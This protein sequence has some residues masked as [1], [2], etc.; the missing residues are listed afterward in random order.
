MTDCLSSSLLLKGCGPGYFS[1]AKG[2]SS[3]LLL[4]NHHDQMGAVF[5]PTKWYRDNIQELLMS[6][7]A[8]FLVFEKVN[9]ESV[10]A[11]SAEARDSVLCYL[12]ME[13]KSTD[14]PSCDFVSF[15]V[16]LKREH[17]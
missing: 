14:N 15:L 12:K 9:A 8:S 2:V 1:S 4:R 6:I 17:S 10:G 5:V 3:I 16:T 11:V 13:P 7:T